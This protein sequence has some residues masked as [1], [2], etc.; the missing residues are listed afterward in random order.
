MSW[1]SSTARRTTSCRCATNWT[2][3]R[4]GGPV[5]RRSCRI[6]TRRAVRGSWSGCTE[7]SRSL[8]GMQDANASC[9]PV[10]GSAR[11]PC[12]G[13]RSP[14]APLLSGGIDSSIVVALMAQASPE[15][16]R[17]FTVGFPDERYD[18]RAYARTVAS[19]YGT[20]HEE[21]EVEEDIA[22]TLPRLAATFDEPFGDE[23]AFPTFLIYDQA[24]RHV[25]VALVGD[26]GV[27]SYAGY[28]RY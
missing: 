19:Q 2:G 5:T 25:T 26:G 8:S 22:S 24:R 27:E 20:V 13:D 21:V 9:S 12:S 6:Y 7:C 23:A 14:T 3:M 10:T 1:R 17:T 28:K 15:P 18:E 11:S 16:V 4:S